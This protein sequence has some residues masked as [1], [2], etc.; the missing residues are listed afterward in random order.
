MRR[1]QPF[2]GMA[3]QFQ[4]LMILYRC[5]LTKNPPAP[6]TFLRMPSLT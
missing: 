6:F 5:F 4:D 1:K 3:S 2:H